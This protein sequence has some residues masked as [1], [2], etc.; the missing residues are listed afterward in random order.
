MLRA[1]RTLLVALQA[2]VEFA[3]AA[4]AAELASLMGFIT[5]TYANT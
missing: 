4:A 1:I 3:R 5:Y 2:L